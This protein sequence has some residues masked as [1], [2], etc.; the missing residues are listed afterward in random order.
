MI[1]TM[2]RDTGRD[3]REGML[4]MIAAMGLLP[5]GDAIAKLLT[6]IASP[7]EVSVWRI[8]MQALFFLPVAILWR[9][10]LRG[11]LLSW[12][13]LIS[14]ALFAVTMIC[15]VSAFQ[16]MPIATAI[17]IF[18]IEPLLLTLL[19]WPF[20][21]ER[22][23]PR[24]FVAVGVGLIGALIVIRPNFAIF[25]PVA[26]FP[27]GAAIAYALNMILLRHATRDHSA[28]TLQ[29]GATFCAAIGLCV[30]YAGSMMLGQKATSLTEA[31]R[32]IFP[33]LICAGGL[34]ALTFLLIT[35]AFSKVE[36]SLLAPFQ[37]LEIVGATI[38]G[39][40]VFGDFPDALT[41]LGTAIILGSGIYVFHRERQAGS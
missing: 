29:I 7:F 25:G 13:A 12:P 27:V 18:F 41:W 33:A 22:P 3:A 6:G 11:A 9:H 4:A 39:L 36:A 20:L 34:L 35:H 10:R 28:L 14:G 1:E 19:A 38:V 26:L 16:K 15:L 31:P 30:L 5:V 8:A 21:G 23:G 2:P 17:A 32:W 40:V 37:Y 24:R